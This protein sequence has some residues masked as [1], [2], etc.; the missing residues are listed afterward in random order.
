MGRS[1]TFNETLC[2]NWG[3]LCPVIGPLCPT[4]TPIYLVFLLGIS[5]R[6]FLLSMETR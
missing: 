5:L 6:I 2:P 4:R 3:T 1:E